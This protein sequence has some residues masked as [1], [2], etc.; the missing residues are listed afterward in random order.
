MSRNSDFQPLHRRGAHARA[1]AHGGR[2]QLGPGSEIPNPR[3]AAQASS[4]ARARQD[5]RAIGLSEFLFGTVASPE[6]S[7]IPK[8][9]TGRRRKDTDP[10]F[11]VDPLKRLPLPSYL[12]FDSQP[13]LPPSLPLPGFWRPTSGH[14]LSH[15]LLLCRSRW[16]QHQGG[17]KPSGHFKMTFASA[18]RTTDRATGGNT[19]SG[20]FHMTICE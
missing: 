16:V 18:D 12:R 14:L 15:P 9:Q 8:A 13:H 19:F 4:R 17:P 1:F 2:R 10:A 11:F 6:G 7:G 20:H 5:E 3:Q